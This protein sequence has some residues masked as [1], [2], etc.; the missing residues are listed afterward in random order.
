MRILHLFMVS[1]ILLLP[2]QAM[3]QPAP[4]D[5]FEP[6]NKMLRFGQVFF[7]AAKSKPQRHWFQQYRDPNT[8]ENGEYHI[9]IHS[10]FRTEFIRSKSYPSDELSSLVIQ[11]PSVRLPLG[12]KF[13]DS[14]TKVKGVF[15]NPTSEKP[16]E[17]RYDNGQPIARI[18]VFRFTRDRLIELE[19]IY[20]HD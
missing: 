4:S 9:A 1:I 16:E 5:G 11:N 17:V 2:Q 10:G 20:D 18:V 12:V 14:P 19:L 13:G 15:G 3:A 7:K 6:A 8:G